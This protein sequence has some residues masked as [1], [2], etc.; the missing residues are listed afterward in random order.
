MTLGINDTLFSSLS[1]V[2]CEKG[3]E[4]L[5]SAVEILI[6]EAM[7]IERAKHINAKLYERTEMRSGYSNGFKPKQL[8]TRL[9]ALNLQIPQVRDSS[10]YPSFLERGL[11][12]ERALSLSL[13]EMYIQ[14][15]STRKVSR[16]LEEMC[17]FEVSS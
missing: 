3:L 9:G 6:N 17:G 13:A 5:G 8:N 14:G 12:S 7:K 4:G 2:L 16:I 11:R 1:E 15:V 10:F